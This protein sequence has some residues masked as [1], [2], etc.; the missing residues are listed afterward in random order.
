MITP[1]GPSTSSTNTSG[2]V[3]AIIGF[4][5]LLALVWLSAM[6]PSTPATYQVVRPS[7]TVAGAMVVETHQHSSWSQTNEY[8]LVTHGPDP[9]QNTLNQM[10]TDCA[11][12]AGVH[13]KIDKK[14]MLIMTTC[15]D[16][17]R[18]MY[19]PSR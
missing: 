16:I 3:L 10:V 8:G 18:G 17:K 11:R 6:P 5:A 4:F 9:I 2:H 1:P 13:D 19:T 14:Q 12:A 7:A 15:I